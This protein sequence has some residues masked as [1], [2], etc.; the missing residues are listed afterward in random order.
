M[1]S[2]YMNH[3]LRSR[4]CKLLQSVIF[5]LDP[6]YIIIDLMYLFPILYNFKNYVKII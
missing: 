3:V 2:K 4:S 6:F 5:M 1:F